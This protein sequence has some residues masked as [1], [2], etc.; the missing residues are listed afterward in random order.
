MGFHYNL[1]PEDCGRGI[2]LMDQLSAHGTENKDAF[3]SYDVVKYYPDLKNIKI[4]L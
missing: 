1:T 3:M 2:L 4:K